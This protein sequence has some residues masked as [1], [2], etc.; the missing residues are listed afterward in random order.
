MTTYRD[1][2]EQEKKELQKFPAYVSLLARGKTGGLDKKELQSVIRFTHIKTFSGNPF[3]SAFFAD[4]EKTFEKNMRDLD[5]TLPQNKEEREMMIRREFG[6]LEPIC[7]KLGR[8]Y[9]REIMNSM[10][11]Y[12]KQVSK[13]HRNILE[14]FIFP[15]P[16]NG[17]TD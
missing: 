9:A 8:D 3:L 6:K 14:Y 11:S 4:V 12:A 7:K 1:L 13:A 15:M 10:K 2:D 16:I 17:I 5:A